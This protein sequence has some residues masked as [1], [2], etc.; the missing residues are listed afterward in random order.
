MTPPSKPYFG[1]W[2][3]CPVSDEHKCSERYLCYKMEEEKEGR[4]RE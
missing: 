4:R 3:H 2:L 1:R